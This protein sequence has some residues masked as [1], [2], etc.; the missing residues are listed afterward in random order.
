MQ[1]GLYDKLVDGELAK[2]LQDL[3]PDLQ[4]LVPAE[5]SDLIAYLAQELAGQAAKLFQ[6]TEDDSEKIASYNRIADIA[7]FSRIPEEKPSALR[8]LISSSAGNKAVL[9]AQPSIPL[10]QMA[11]LTNAKGE[12]KVG[13][14]LKTELLSADRVDILMAFVKHSGL[15][16]LYEPLKNLRDKGVPVRLITSAYMGATDTSAIRAL[17]EELKVSVKVDYLARAN[18]LHAK[19]WLLE[20]NTGFTTAFIGSSNMSL[21]AMSNG[22]E[23]NV[24]FSEAKAPELIEK[25]RIAFDSYW[26]SSDFEPFQATPS[27]LQKLDEALDR[28][29]GVQAGDL[30]RLTISSIDVRPLPFQKQMLDELEVERV[31]HGRHA[32]LVVAAT[33][34]GKT[35]LSALDYARLRAAG[36]TGRL[37]FVAHTKE[38]LE[39][40]RATFCQVLKDSEFGE[41]LVDGQVPKANQF[42]F[43]SVQSLTSQGRYK[44]YPR[45]HF[46]M[47]IV[48]EFHHA[49]AASYR[50]LIG[51]FEPK[52][53]L[54]LTATPERT[55]G[56]RVQDEFF[57]GRIATE[58]RLWDAL[59]QEIL[60]P[61]DYFGIGDDAD[62]SNLNWT[63]GSYDASGLSNL[64]TGDHARA[65]L[66]F[67]ELV[68][69]F[70]DLANLKA[71]A[72]CASAD[73]ARFMTEFFESQGIPSAMVLGTTSTSE[74]SDA[75]RAFRSG[76]TKILLSVN[77][78]NEGF[79]VPDAN[80]I[81]MLRPTESPLVFLQQLGRG[82]RRSP[83]KSSVLVLDFVGNHR[84]EYRHDLRL[85]SITGRNRG[86]LEADIKAGFPFLP[87]G[88]SINL[89]RKSRERIL[90]SLKAQ[91]GPGSTF[92]QSE[93]ASIRPESL[94]DYLLKSGRE[95][96]EI[97]RNRGVSWT[98]LSKGLGQG[99]SRLSLIRN[100]IHA[101]DLQR[102]EKYLEILAGKHSKWANS[103]ETDKSFLNMFYW[104]LYPS[105]S[106][107]H[108]IDEAIE[109][110]TS[111]HNF[112][113]ELSELLSLLADK[114]RTK[115]FPLRIGN[116]LSALRGHAS[117]TRAELLGALGWSTLENS[118]FGKP[119]RLNTSS[120]PSDHREGVAWMPEANLE[121]L[122]VTLQKGNEFSASTRYLDYAENQDTFHWESQNRTTPESPTG[123]RYINQRSREVDVLL[124][125]RESAAGL[126]GLTQTYKLA[127]LVDYL[128]HQ[129]SAPMAIWWKL[130]EPLDVQMWKTASA[131]RVA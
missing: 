24:R 28:A 26:N 69:K 90:A 124:A 80:A 53:F 81:L 111:D 122:L 110:I 74:R 36:R 108:S 62:Y 72:F 107:H 39:Q 116:Q 125:L 130:R 20:R 22:L 4:V 65:K 97:Y 99:D 101:D 18:R 45:D 100:F 105:G 61:F 25:V 83:G 127:G 56:V 8:G 87:S 10:S 129:G 126:G 6:Q 77:V 59:E 73:H 9:E 93:V 17:V 51:H 32:N 119:S 60:T 57:E 75:I 117:Y 2:N 63:R 55:D 114:N 43:A 7:G 40:A 128:K 85:S 13:S 34:S 52:E 12:P 66:V 84:S 48:D 131:I 70:G 50:T 113:A 94:A 49:E 123:Q 86:A 79:D 14:E 121:L 109:E 1:D 37:L 82:L 3:T 27:D 16:L 5:S 106:S 120:K 103:S 21:A 68:R 44:Q 92:L 33:G 38:I 71:L 31:D 54:G 29:K 98:S 78:F 89:D 115:T 58:L 118:M 35:V 19:A 11:L 112:V 102:I 46:D 64:L 47:V 91:V 67:N 15:N 104:N 42:V 96:W 76:Q 88:V 23:W 41:L 30:N 95:I